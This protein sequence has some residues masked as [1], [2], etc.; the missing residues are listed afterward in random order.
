MAEKMVDFAVQIR[1]LREL[2]DCWKSDVRSH[3]FGEQWPFD[4]SQRGMGST[5]VVVGEEVGAE[6]GRPGL[7]SHAMVLTTCDADLVDDGQVQCVGREIDHAPEGGLPFVQV[8]MLA[9]K[10]GSVPDP[11]ELEAT[12]YLTNR[13]QGYMART[14]P[15]R[16]WVR[17]GRDLIDRGFRLHS[18]GSVLLAAYRMDFPDVVKA[19]ALLVTG[20]DRRVDAFDSVAAEF[21]VLSGR[22]RKLVLAG[23][24]VY[25]CPDLDCDACDEKPICDALKDVAV[26]YRKL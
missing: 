5:S 19:Q 4:I 23:T 9:L 8:V 11:Y 15:G 18:L 3:H 13:V 26:R 2:V 25:D 20:D 6:L 1:R 12:Q 16:L 17:V 24:G 10:P 7:A 22:H 21:K 14:V